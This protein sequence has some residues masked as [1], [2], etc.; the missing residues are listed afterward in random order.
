M[1][2][3]LN[4][5]KY[6]VYQLLESKSRYVAVPKEQ[7]EIISNAISEY[8]N[9]GAVPSDRKVQGILLEKENNDFLSDGP[10]QLKEVTINVLRIK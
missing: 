1:K 3:Q 6:T 2:Y 10:A 4:N 9:I 7:T 8:G 5:E